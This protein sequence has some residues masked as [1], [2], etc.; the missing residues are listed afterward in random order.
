MAGVAGVVLARGRDTTRAAR[1]ALMG[2]LLQVALVVLLRLV[3]VVLAGL[4][5]TAVGVEVAATTLKPSPI[6]RFDATRCSQMGGPRGLRR[7]W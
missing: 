5:S 3:L 1:L 6:A 7:R 4:L 2:T